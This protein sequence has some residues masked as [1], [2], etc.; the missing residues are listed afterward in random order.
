MLDLSSK[1]LLD[2]ITDFLG[3]G[4][5]VDEILEFQISERHNQYLQQL[6]NKSKHQVLSSEE[7]QEI[8]DMLRIANFLT[9]IKAKARVNLRGLLSKNI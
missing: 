3:S 7:R 5:T 9:I 2:E 4:P 6:I 8:E 1:A